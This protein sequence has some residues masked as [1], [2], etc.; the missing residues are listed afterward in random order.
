V[1]LAKRW[2]LVVFSDAVTDRKQRRATQIEQIVS[3]HRTEQVEVLQPQ[4]GNTVTVTAVEAELDLA[5]EQRDTHATLVLIAG[6]MPGEIY[7]LGAATVIGR[8][9]LADIAI[10]DSAVSRRHAR[11]LV[12]GDTH[13]VEDL[14]SAN[15][16]FV[17]NV[18]ITER[19]LADG[20]RIQ[21]GPR[22]VLRFALL[23]EDELR[24]QRQLFES[25]TR[26]PLT[27]AYNKKYVTDRLVAEVAHALRHHSSLEVVVF[28][29]DKFKQVNDVYGHLVGDAVLRTVADGVH[30]LVRGED[31]FARFGGEEFV[32]ITRGS[33]AARLAERIRVA[34]EALVVP[35][36]RGPLRVT[37]S[38]GVARLD[39]LTAEITADA[40]LDKADLR[41]LEAKRAGR[42]RVCS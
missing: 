36:D 27:G 40:L 15:G 7:A 8:D 30:A 4:F 26:D 12:R 25:S 16:T 2:P 3:P 42:N 6:P 23:D 39:E 1:Q 22:V 5:L 11:V 24:M 18:R 28:D 17:G 29:L 37:V 19:V 14:G 38:L 32:V 33:D 10:D 9:P 41:L 35:T 34:V 13:V 31:V 20:D 21:L